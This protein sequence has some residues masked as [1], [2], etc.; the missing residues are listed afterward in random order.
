MTTYDDAIT[1]QN[2]DG[3][4]HI[5][6]F[7]KA[8]ETSFVWNGVEDVVEVCRGG[9]GEPVSDTF[10]LMTYAVDNART[11]LRSFEDACQRYLVAKIRERLFTKDEDGSL[12]LY[13]W[14]VTNPLQLP[15]TDLADLAVER[16]V[17]GTFDFALPA[18][19]CDDVKAKTGEWPYGLVWSYPER[20]IFGEPFA[21]TTEA[22]AL[23]TKYEE[24][25]RG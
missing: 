12:V 14:N 3:T 13:D 16:G 21:L 1:P 25:T 15:L 5:A 2:A 17:L 22:A 11:L 10:P 18:P 7:D 23:L 9:Y 24:A 4:A 6:Y 20:S 19:W 8:T